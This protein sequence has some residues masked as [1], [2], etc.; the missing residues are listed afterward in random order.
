MTRLLLATAAVLA[1]L[2]VAC[3][4]DD[5]SAT[6]TPAPTA[7]SVSATA[8]AN[9]AKQF[10]S[11]KSPLAV[12]LTADD[13]W[14]IDYDAADSFVLKRRGDADYPTGYIEVFAPAA[15]FSDDGL[16][17]EAV[18]ADLAGW[19]RTYPRLTVQDESAATLGGI[20]GTEFDIASE[21]DAEFPL[22]QYADGTNFEMRF[23]D[24]L[25]LYVLDGQTS[26]IL[27][28]ESTETPSQITR[29]LPLSEPVVQSIEFASP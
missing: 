3:G 1:M 26:A 14:S 27:V 11:E 2:A 5:D 4:G 12:T 21:G 16:T 19:V 8:T 6:T 25:R 17:T 28:V 18:P 7:A 29:F 23:S 13:S 22:F 20:S 24:R 15:V 9:A 10:T